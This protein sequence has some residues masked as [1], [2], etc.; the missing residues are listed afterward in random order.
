M[1]MRAIDCICTFDWLAATLITQIAMISALAKQLLLCGGDTSELRRP[2]RCPDSSSPI[3][4]LVA[5][6]EQPRLPLGNPVV[7]V[8]QQAA[9]CWQLRELHANV[10]HRSAKRTIDIPCMFKSIACLQNDG[11]FANRLHRVTIMTPVCRQT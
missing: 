9:R 8:E 1:L 2:S 4:K 7:P 10:D 11:L 5:P 3:Q 6:V